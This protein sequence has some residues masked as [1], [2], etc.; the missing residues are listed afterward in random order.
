M[1]TK[2]TLPLLITIADQRIAHL[3]WYTRFILKHIL[4]SADQIFTQDVHKSQSLL[5]LSARTSLVRSV[6][7]GDAFA[8]QI[9]FAY[10]VLFE[11]CLHH[12]KK[13]I[14]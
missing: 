1:R 12:T 10:S 11:K 6:G 14:F 2:K 5:S 13:E 4:G 9:R 3:P 8:N 7:D